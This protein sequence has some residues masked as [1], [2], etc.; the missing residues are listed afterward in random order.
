[1]RNRMRRRA[2]RGTTPLLLL[3][4]VVD[5]LVD[6]GDLFDPRVALAVLH[7]E[8]ILERPVHVVSDIRYLPGELL[9]GVARYSPTPVPPV[10][11]STLNSFPHAGHLAGTAA[12]PLSLIWR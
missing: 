4:R 6:L 3:R 5:A 9:Q 11:M 8:Q 7:L 10:P 12:E 2:M 1:M